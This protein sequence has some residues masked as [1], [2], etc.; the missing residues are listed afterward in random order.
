MARRRAPE[1]DT[2]D[3]L[4]IR[5]FRQSAQPENSVTEMFAAVLQADAAACR[6]YWRVIT[7][8]RSAAVRGATGPITVKTQVRT[9]TNAYLDMIVRRGPYSVA[10]EH[11]LD[12]P[13]G[14]RQLER[15]LDVPRGEVTHVA[16]VSR[17]RQDVAREVLA[18]ARYAR[19][20]RDEH[21]FRWPAFDPLLKA[22]AARGLADAAKVRA[23]FGEIGLGPAHRLLSE[24]GAMGSDERLTYDRAMLERLRPL[25]RILEARG[26]E[27]VDSSLR[28]DRTS[29]VY[30]LDGPSTQL[31]E[32]RLNPLSSAAALLVY[33]KTTSW[34][35]RS[36]LAKALEVS[37]VRD[38]WPGTSIRRTR[39]RKKSSRGTDWHIE[40]RLLWESL[41]QRASTRA[42]VP[43]R[44]KDAVLSIMRAAAPDS[45]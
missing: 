8:G 23:L 16:L 27:H 45:V 3:G 2:A 9:S 34:D 31:P 10:V 7:V 15:Y 22:S 43:D 1:I 37:G 21:Y 12:A 36:K 24:F 35:K 13:L 25:M 19:P 28:N 4:F 11:K 44:I 30:A 26:W 39:S 33:L 32:V 41:L 6:A 14:P 17:A 29:E 18:S 5:L 20:G 40:V 38:R 42:A